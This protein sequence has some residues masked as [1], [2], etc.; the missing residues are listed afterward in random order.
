MLFFFPI[1]A[2]KLFSDLAFKGQFNACTSQDG[3]DVEK[4]MQVSVF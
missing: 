2:D 1:S 3:K 4:T